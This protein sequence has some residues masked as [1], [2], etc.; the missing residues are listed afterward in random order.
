M[1]IWGSPFSVKSLLPGGLGR[2]ISNPLGGSICLGRHIMY[3][4]LG[5]IMVA[6][7][8]WQQ[9]FGPSLYPLGK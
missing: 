4:P 7:N 5:K 8:N 3:R 1:A 6:V 9:L 2:L